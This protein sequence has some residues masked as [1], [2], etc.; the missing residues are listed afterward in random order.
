MSS[1]VTKRSIVLMG[2]KTSVSLEMEFWDG[3]RKIASSQGVQLARLIEQID[4]G[5]QRGANLSSAI[6]VFVFKQLCEKIQEKQFSE[7]WA[8]QRDQPR[9]L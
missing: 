4:R 7:Q 9:H 6:R 1:T 2:H 3:L 8:T 5:R